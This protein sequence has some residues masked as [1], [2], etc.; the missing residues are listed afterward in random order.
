MNNLYE[1]YKN[2]YKRADKEQKKNHLNRWVVS[3]ADFTTVLLAI[4]M[5]LWAYN[6][7]N[8]SDTAEAKIKKEE[9]KRQ[10]EQIKDKGPNY[11]LDGVKNPSDSK[12]I[13]IIE[14][15]KMANNINSTLEG[16]NKV[17]IITQKGQITIRLGEGV[18]FDEGSAIIKP[19]AKKTLDKLA[20]QIKNCD[21][22]IRIEGHSDNTPIRNSKYSS[23]WELSSARAVNIVR[24]LI[25]NSKIEKSRLSASGYADNVPVATNET[26]EGRAKNRRVDIIIIN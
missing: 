17:E 9:Q 7:L 10:E 24:Y 18:L 15:E 23:N 21:N 12:D 4:F 19:N 3:Y 11:L 26:Q 22:K 1:K 6:G 14:F 13:K 16:E 20:Q 2:F 5:V 8:I 25:E